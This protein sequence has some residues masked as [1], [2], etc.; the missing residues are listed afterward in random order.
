MVADLACRITE[1]DDSSYL[2]IVNGSDDSANP[3][4]DEDFLDIRVLARHLQDVFHFP[5]V[6][7]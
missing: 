5:F 1:F 3:V 4:E 2:F 7:G 6:L